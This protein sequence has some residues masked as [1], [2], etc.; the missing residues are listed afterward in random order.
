MDDEAYEIA[1]SVPSKYFNYIPEIS[2]APGN[3]YFVIH[4]NRN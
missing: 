1:T 3:Y 2:L 4:P